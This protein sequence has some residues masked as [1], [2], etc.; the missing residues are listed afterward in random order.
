MAP[1]ISVQSGGGARANQ[2]KGQAM[3]AYIIMIGLVAGCGG[4]LFG[5]DI[6]V[7]GGV[8]SMP[9]FQEKFF[10]SVYEKAQAAEAGDTDPYCTFDDQLLQLFSSSLY[11]AGMFISLPA[12]ILTRRM[13]R[14]ITMLIASIF[15]LVG[16]GINAG[17]VNVAML[18]VGRILLGFGIG[19]ANSVVPLYLSEAAPHKWRGAMTMLFQLTVTIGIFA[20]SLINYGVNEHGG[21]EG[22]RLSL[23][24]AAVPAIILFIASL[25]LPETPNSLI[26]RGRVEEGRRVLAKLRNIS[27]EDV[28]TEFEDIR[29]AAVTATAVSP[30]AQWRALFA[31]RNRPALITTCLIAGFQQL[32]GINAIMF[33]A[34]QIFQTIGSG[35]SSAL[36][37]AVVINSVNV[38][39]TFVAI[40]AVDRF[41]RR[42]LFLEGGVQ[43]IATLFAAGALIAVEFNKYTSLPSSAAAG[44]LAIVCIYDAGFSWSWGPLGW[45]VPSE[46]QAMD[47]RGAGMGA[48]VIINFLFTFF[49]G[50]AFLSMMCGMKFGVYFFFGAWVIIMTL[51]IYFFLPETSGVPIEE[52]QL[53][54]A[55][56][57]LWRKVM[58]TSADEV[59]AASE[60]RDL[61]VKQGQAESGSF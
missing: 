58:G 27:T 45:L 11:L 25:I 8:I 15:F 18:I 30:S 20:A 12:A 55:R 56:H 10:P 54:F 41:G 26:E 23:G 32:T 29:E 46:I 3:H 6:G 1:A 51:F 52:V 19:S 53:T 57:P 24:L 7:S 14:K 42:G 9:H 35:H 60:K 31:P 43:M 4:L 21:S 17:A 39:C 44:L 47:V 40:Y 28:E 59:I 38:A 5:Y 50:Q 2:Y 61:V 48:A 49:I 13:G 16:S 22:W 37:S 36:L 34:P 33:Y